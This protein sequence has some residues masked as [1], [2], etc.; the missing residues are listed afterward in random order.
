MYIWQ[1][2]IR[3]V[4]LCVKTMCE[5]RLGFYS[6]CSQYVELGRLHDLVVETSSF[7]MLMTLP[8]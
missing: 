3:Y 2:W 8:T 5:A 6:F 7:L 1:N 4:I